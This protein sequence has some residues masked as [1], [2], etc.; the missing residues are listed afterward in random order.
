MR[1]KV[2]TIIIS[3]STLEPVTK[4]TLHRSTLWLILI[5][6]IILVTYGILGSLKFHEESKLYAEYVKIKKENKELEKASKTLSQ[7]RKKEVIIRKFL[8]L[9]PN[10]DKNGGAGRGGPDSSSLEL[11]DF[12][13][14]KNNF[15][16]AFSQLKP[17]G[18]GTS[19]FQEAALLDL[20]FQ[21]LIDF[22]EDQKTELDSLP[23][24]TPIPVSE[25]WI[26][27]RFG[28]RRSPFTGLKEFHK[29]LDLSANRGTPII[30]P[31]DGK[32][33][34]IG[35]KG[36]LGKTIKIKHNSHYETVYGHLLKY[37]VKINQKVK[38]GDIIGY[39]GKTGRSTG[40][41]VHYE[42]RKDKKRVDPYPYLLNWGK[43]ELLAAKNF[44]IE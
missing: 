42:I 17:M 41:H 21:E 18:G 5:T 26:S 9:E 29:G 6:S 12:Q 19:I 44:T 31:G 15:L 7:I 43:G 3:P 38:R 8:G 4:F 23:T 32:I 25:A 33:S 22:L 27:S 35:S 24:L 28:I 37:N 30:A 39:V 40:Y 10:S 16:S 14:D 34:F 2:Y 1:K 13:L 11:E 36:P 20:D